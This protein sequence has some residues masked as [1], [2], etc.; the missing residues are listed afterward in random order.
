ML[1]SSPTSSPELN[2]VLDELVSSAS[3]ILG[4]NFCGAHLQGSFAVGDADVYSDV[5]FVIVTHG[6]V[7]AAQEAA[8]GVLHARLP[9]LDIEWAQHL[10]GSYIPKDALRRVD[11]SRRSYL[12]V[13]NGSTALERSNH[14]N[15]AV[16]RWV[17]R[18]HGAT[19]AGPD[20]KV[21]VVEVTADD[22]RSEIRQAL[23]VR[24]GDLRETAARDEQWNAWLQPC[25]RPRLLPHAAHAGL[26][27]GGLEAG[28]RALG[29]RRPSSPV[30][31]PDPARSGRP[32][33]PW[34]RVHQPADPTMV[35]E[36]WQFIDYA[37]RFA[38]L[39]P[40]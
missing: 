34:L 29:A 21:L 6:E 9:T 11:P 1:N 31:A 27:S 18:E 39:P 35:A 24:T 26:R 13:D 8:L 10:E 16:V 28:S 2:A 12:Y 22:L 38:G 7:N 17:L 36:T 37:Q 3:A 15:T 5:D 30:G 19:L 4:E 33:D 32:A 40:S 25:T 20:P 23:P 14:D